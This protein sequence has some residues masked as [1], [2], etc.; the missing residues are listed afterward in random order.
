VFATARDAGI[1]HLRVFTPPCAC[2]LRAPLAGAHLFDVQRGGWGRALQ[3]VLRI[4]NLPRK[5]FKCSTELRF[6]Q[7]SRRVTKGM[8][9][10]LVYKQR[11]QHMEQRAHYMIHMGWLRL[12]GSLKLGRAAARRNAPK[13]Q[14][15]I[16]VGPHSGGLS[17]Q[18]HNT[19][20]L[21]GNFQYRGFICQNTQYRGFIKDIKEILKISKINPR[22][23]KVNTDT[24][25][26]YEFWQINPRYWKFPDKP[27]VL[28]MLADKPRNVDL[29]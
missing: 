20:C 1:E 29:P 27:P 19:G 14:R 5:D 15:V 12:V 18:M 11:A 2:P 13:Q 17:A 8:G 26:Y 10:L 7:Y 21:S 9:C 3:F 22:N 6:R 16:R 25:R 28:C 24:P 4:W 23:V